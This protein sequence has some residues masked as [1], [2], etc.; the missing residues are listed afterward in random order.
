MK[1]EPIIFPFFPGFISESFEPGLFECIETWEQWLVEVQA[2]PDSPLKEYALASAKW[3][4]AMKRQYL[5]AK[6][7]GVEWLH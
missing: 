2:M 1:D 6:R 4:I 3:T 7:H 5:R